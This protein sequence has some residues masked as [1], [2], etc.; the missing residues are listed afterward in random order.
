MI[1]KRIDWIDCVK[2]ITILLVIISH[3]VSNAIIRG[4]IFSFHM[5]LF[6][7]VSCMTFK[8]S[9]NIPMFK[10]KMVKALKH[11]VSPILIIWLL[12]ILIEW[13]HVLVGSSKTDINFSYYMKKVEVLFWGSGVNVVQNGRCVAALG[14][15]WFLF[16]LFLGRCLF[17]FIQ[18]KVKGR[19]LVEVICLLSGLGVILGEFCWLPFSVDIALAIQPFFYIGH[20]FPK[21]KLEQKEFLKF[22]L[23]FGV[24]GLTFALC[25]ILSSSYLE[26]APRRY[27]LY[28]FSYFV[29]IAGTTMVCEFSMFLR[30][31]TELYKI[32]CYLGK[33]SLYL[34]CIH[35]MDGIWHPVWSIAGN[36]YI[37][38][39]L[40]VVSDVFVFGLVMLLVSIFNKL[41]IISFRRK[42]IH[43]GNDAK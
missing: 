27:V 23:W 21:E 13:G 1:N 20:K 35:C 4:A 38:S 8:C 28:P 37:A 32:F 22:I 42:V 41:V 14:I 18:I 3:T 7:I 17:D 33:Y 30:T 15:P 2:G 19:L 40:R 36:Q 6:F 16:A 12:G 24:W 43:G 10:N 29:A 31:R 39:V 5:P 25:Y 26:L 11:L 34:L 9:D